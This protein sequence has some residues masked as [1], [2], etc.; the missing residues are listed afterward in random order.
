ER[1]MTADNAT[2]TVSGNFDRALAFRAIRRYFGSWLKADKRVPVTFRNA[3]DPPAGSL[4]IPSPK[5]DVAAVRAAIRGSA[6][7]D[8]D[9]A[10]SLVL[11]AIMK[12]RLT[13]GLTSKETGGGSVVMR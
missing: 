10:A 12:S 1:F 2:V 7:S 5:S 6:R 9:F 3:D 8:K 13:N 4:T 11:T